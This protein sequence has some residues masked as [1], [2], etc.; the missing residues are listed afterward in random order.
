MQPAAVSLLVF[1]PPLLCGCAYQDAQVAHKAERGLV[2]LSVADLDMCAGLPTKTERINPGTELRSYERN[3]TT[4]SGVNITFPVIGGGVN[5]GNG[6]YCHVT[7]KVVNGQV[8][9]LS[10]AGDTSVA[11][12]DDA[13]CAPIVRTCV[14]QKGH[15]QAADSAVI[16]SRR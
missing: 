6:G 11:G 7:F 1:L 14:A 4:N 10:Y 2:G 12:A 15:E 3:E 9:A 16:S 5:V 8:T 13:I